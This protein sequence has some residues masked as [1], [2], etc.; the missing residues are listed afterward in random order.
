MTEKETKTELKKAPKIP[1]PKKLESKQ[2]WSSTEKQASKDVYGCEILLDNGSIED[3]SK[4]E[5][6]ND[7][8]II[9]YHV[10]DKVCYDLTRGQKTKLFDM[11]WDKFK[12]ELKDISWGRGTISPKLWRYS[13]AKP[14]KK[15]R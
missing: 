2:N 12:G 5:Y 8:F 10:D 14:A 3:C 15:K 6:P 7:A 11:Y 4:P 9:K 1:D 13:S